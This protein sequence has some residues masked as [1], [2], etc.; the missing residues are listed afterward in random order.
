M[1][2]T[3][4]EKRLVNRQAKSE[5]NIQILRLGLQNLEVASIRDVLEIGCGIGMVSAWLAQNYAMNVRGADFDPDQ[6]ELARRINPENERLQ[7]SVEDAANLTFRSFSFDMVVSQNV[8][9]HIHDW[10]TAI[11]EVRR[12]LKPGGFFIW[13]DLTFSAFTKKIMKPVFEGHGLYTLEEIKAAFH[14][15]KFAERYYEKVPHFLFAH[16]HFV[17]EKR[18]YPGAG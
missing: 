17:L 12:V 7:F 2:M 13:Y 4:F 1:A 11:S 5:R 14:E 15:E 3:G 9:H 8:F 18:I 10:K 16:H 6:I